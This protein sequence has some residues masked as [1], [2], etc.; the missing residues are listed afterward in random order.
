MKAQARTRG[1][2]T[3]ACAA[4]ATSGLWV[5]FVC[6]NQ[7]WR[8]FTFLELHAQM[9]CESWLWCAAAQCVLGTERPSAFTAG[10]AD[11]C[12]VISWGL[13]CSLWN[14]G[15]ALDIFRGAV[16]ALT[17]YRSWCWNVT[18]GGQPLG[19]P[20]C[21]T[22][23]HHVSSRPL[24]LGGAVHVGSVPFAVQFSNNVVVLRHGTMLLCPDMSQ[25]VSLS[26]VP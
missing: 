5:W 4:G 6:S 13:T 2:L 10:V 19:K 1:E 17:A 18:W 9:K 8:G 23:S 7:E 22:G 16:L 12:C 20:C 11:S 25:A 3:W 26:C 14:F 15:G 21:L 24:T